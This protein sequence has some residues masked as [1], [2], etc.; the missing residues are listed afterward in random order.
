MFFW[1]KQPDEEAVK[2]VVGCVLMLALP[3]AGLDEA[4]QTLLEIREFHGGSRLIATSSPAPLQR[5]TGTAV[6]VRDRSPFV[7]EN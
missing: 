4:V 6:G 1:A 3:S 7:F 5:A 2:R